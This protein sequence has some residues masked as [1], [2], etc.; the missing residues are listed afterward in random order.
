VGI[1]VL[2]LPL[3]EGPSTLAREPLLRQRFCLCSAKRDVRHAVQLE[4][5]RWL[6]RNWYAEAQQG[7]RSDP[8]AP[9]FVAIRNEVQKKGQNPINTVPLSHLRE[10][11][12]SQLAG[13]S[14]SHVLVLPSKSSDGEWTDATAV[15]SASFRLLV[16]VV[17]DGYERFKT[18]V[19]PR[20]HYTESNF[21]AQGLTLADALAE[22]GFPSGWAT[23]AP[24]GPDPWR[25]LRAQ[26]PSC[27][28]ALNELFLKYLGRSIVDPHEAA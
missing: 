13:G 24:S 27:A 5:S 28:L 25:V 26:Q 20:W 12:A 7:L 21:K 6:R 15:T 19:D 11:L 2:S 17:F 16:S 1:G 9:H 22:L 8:L 4:W 18:I 23:A 14:R 10:H 3:S